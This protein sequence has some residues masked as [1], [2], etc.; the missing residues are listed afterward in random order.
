M[1]TVDTARDTARTPAQRPARAPG[2]R[3]QRPAPE[4]APGFAHLDLDG[5]R[6]LRHTLS[7][8]ES[9]V[10]YWRRII[11]A[12]LDV[13]RDSRA[14][15]GGFDASRL[16][17]VLTDQRVGAGR[18]ALVEVLD[19][20]DAAAI[21]PLPDLARLWAREVALDDAEAVLAL[22]AD[23]LVAEAQLSTYRSALHDRIGAA[24]SELIARYREEPTLCLSA[25]PLEEHRPARHAV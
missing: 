21:P 24:T 17:P 1:A 19:H 18:A 4:R 23:L 20:A 16:A 25:L 11:Q 7:Q 13:L 14:R 6:G 9:A 5:L 8:E 2:A 10:S 15:T 3:G 22:E 12:R